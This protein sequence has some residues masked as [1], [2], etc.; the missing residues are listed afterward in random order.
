MGVDGQDE[1]EM[2]QGNR[3]RRADESRRRKDRCKRRRSGETREHNLW[4]EDVG[5]RNN[6]LVEP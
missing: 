1:I 4:M 5:G 3:I 6:T 2:R